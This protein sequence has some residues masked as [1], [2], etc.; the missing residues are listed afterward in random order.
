M[1][2]VPRECYRQKVLQELRGGNGHCGGRDG[3]APAEKAEYALS[4]ERKAG[5]RL[6]SEKAF[7]ARRAKEQQS[8]TVDA[9]PIDYFCCHSLYICFCVCAQ[10]FSQV[11]VEA[12]HLQRCLFSHLKKLCSLSLF[13]SFLLSLY[14]IYGFAYGVSLIKPLWVSMGKQVTKLAVH[15]DH[16]QGTFQSCRFL[17]PTPEILTIGSDVGPG[18]MHYFKSS[19]LFHLAWS[20]V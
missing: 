10:I 14:G 19:F 15:H 8:R 11:Q 20:K 13:H 5:L 4:L 3:R 17:C 6:G 16:P 1:C 7:L 18:N 9:L 12:I 2:P